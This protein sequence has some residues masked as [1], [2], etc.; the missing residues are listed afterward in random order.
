MTELVYDIGMGDGDDS[1]FYLL[2]GFRVVAV[3][4]DPSLCDAARVRL[5]A[6]I[7]KGQLT[8]VNRA[9]VAKAG[10][11]T[12]HRSSTPGWGTVVE[13]WHRYNV[14]HGVAADSIVVDGATLA[15]LVKVDDPPFYL[16]IDIEGMDRAALDSLAAT[17]VR[18]RYISIE[19]S[20]ERSPTMASISSEFATLA[21]LGYDRFKI[22]D[23]ARVP[24]Q[25]PEKPARMGKYI[26]YTFTDSASGMFGEEAPGEWQSAH[27]ALL[28]FRQLCRKHW[29][30]L[31]LHRKTRLYPHYVGI[32]VRLFG[33]SPNLGWYDIHAKHSSVE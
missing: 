9:V 15:E 24:E 18:P 8:I 29:L 2:K 27:A 25:V 17:T 33:H 3:E 26:P 23:Q 14:A 30:P 11:A 4:A 1:L 12:L 19:T 5:R 22:V 10:P 7:E 31:L 6:F 20:F 21:K 13:N 32:M 16:K 28:S